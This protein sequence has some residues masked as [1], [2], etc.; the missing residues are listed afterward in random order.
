MRTLALALL[1]VATLLPAQGASQALDATRLVGHWSGS[2]TFSNADMQKKV[3]SLPF[4]VEFNADRSA[5][6][7]VGNA[8]LQDARVK[9]T[10]DLIEV[11]A[12]LAGSIGTDP[13]LAKD[14]LVLLVTRINDGTIEAEFHLKSNFAF[15]PR[16]RDGR[17]V[18][19]R[20]RE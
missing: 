3:G 14:H 7:R 9:S 5:T 11:R 18:L 12:K 13:V 8:T 1:V 10:R 2:G 16:M 15:D 19:T 17:V 20:I 4:V 6:G